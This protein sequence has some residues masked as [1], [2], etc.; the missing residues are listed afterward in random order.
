VET[1]PKDEG[2]LNDSPNEKR[3]QERHHRTMIGVVKSDKMDK[4]RVVVVERRFPH[5]KYGKFITRRSPYKV[6]DEK[7]ETRAGDRVMIIESKPMSRDKRWRMLKL[8][9]RPA[10][11]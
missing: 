4:T 1:K 5:P 10:T 3:G 8:L 2:R 9:E 7:N 6:H 11:A